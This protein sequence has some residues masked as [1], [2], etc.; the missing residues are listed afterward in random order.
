MATTPKEYFEVSVPKKLEDKPE[1]AQKINAI[2]QFEISGD[3]GGTWTVD[4]VNSKVHEG[5][6]ANAKCTVK[7]KSED[8]MKIVNGQLNAQMAFMSGKLKIG[9]DMGLAM[10]LGDLLKA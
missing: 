5:E 8:F 4:L 3:D 6:D 7:T 9:G 2:Y 1:L 10:K